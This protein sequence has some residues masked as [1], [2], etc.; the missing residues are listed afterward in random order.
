MK[1]PPEQDHNVGEALETIGFSGFESETPLPFWPFIDL[2][3]ISSYII[4]VSHLVF[5][6]AWTIFSNFHVTSLPLV[7]SPPAP[8]LGD[9]SQT[10]MEGTKQGN[11]TKQLS[12]ISAEYVPS[13]DATKPHILN[14]GKRQLRGD[15]LA[16]EVIMNSL[17]SRTIGRLQSPC[18]GVVD[19]VS[20]QF[21]RDVHTT[22]NV[23]SCEA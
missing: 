22:F 9:N 8:H 15:V 20:E 12:N 16:Q 7:P 19:Q 1:D 21:S 13:Q 3:C 17:R 18:A 23:G 14:I 5:I 2:I 10:N 4:P 6:G 11:N